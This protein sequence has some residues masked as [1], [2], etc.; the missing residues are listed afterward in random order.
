MSLDL[1]DNAQAVLLLCSPLIRGRGKEQ[2]TVKLFSPSEYN[3]LHQILTKLKMEPSMLF[4]KEGLDILFENLDLTWDKERIQELLNR[5]FQLSI[6]VEHWNAHG[7]WI[8]C[9][10]DP[11]YPERLKNLGHNAPPIIYCCGPIEL[12]VGGGLAVVG[13][14]AI[15]HDVL[16]FTQQVGMHCAKDNLTLVSGGARGV[17]QE[18]MFS[19]L[20]SGGRVIGV[21]AERLADAALSSKS[22]P[23]L[24]KELLLISPFDPEVRFNVGNAMSRNKLIYAMSDFGLVVESGFEKGGTWA[25][26]TELFKSKSDIPLF[27]RADEGAGKGNMALLDKGGIP[28]PKEFPEKPLGDHLL[29]LSQKQPIK[30]TSEKQLKLDI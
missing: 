6:C 29:N 10:S 7:I 13:S 11:Q 30:K 21:L 1:S 16:K 18:S 26:A 27:I 9:N 17:D 12:I 4:E 14:R 2:S 8:L 25:G 5:G 20:D 15:A 22:R 28:W 3:D 23:Y 19:C 24:D